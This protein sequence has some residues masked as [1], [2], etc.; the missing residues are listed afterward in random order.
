M[1]EDGCTGRS[2][3]SGGRLFII[4]IFLLIDATLTARNCEFRHY[5]KSVAN[6]FAI[7][8]R[9]G[10][11]LTLENVQITSTSGSGIGV[12]GGS[13]FISSSTVSNCKT[14]GILITASLDGSVP[15]SATI[16]KECM[17]VKNGGVGILA[18][19]DASVKLSKSAVVGGNKGG[20]RLEKGYNAAIEL[21]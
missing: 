12:E 8:V 21:F 4:C 1:K 10:A 14:H 9:E 20:D 3:R 11:T 19:E 13:L 18:L 5:S 2:D 16:G 15:G 6:N 17:I 7:Y